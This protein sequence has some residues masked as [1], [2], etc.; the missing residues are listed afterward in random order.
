MLYLPGTSLKTVPSRFKTSTSRANCPQYFSIYSLIHPNE[1][2]NRNFIEI[3][4]GNPLVI[5][6]NDELSIID[7]EYLDKDRSKDLLVY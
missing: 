6:F 4:T 5:K 1:K 2:Y 7:C 3:P